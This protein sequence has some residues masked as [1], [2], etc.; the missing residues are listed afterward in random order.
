M[1]IH[2][3]PGLEDDLQERIQNLQAE[4]AQ[5]A[6]SRQKQIDRIG[7]TEGPPPG[8]QAE[9]D[10]NADLY[11]K[12]EAW[13]ALFENERRALDGIYPSPVVTETMIGDAAQ[14]I[15]P[16]DP[17]F[18]IPPVAGGMDPVYANCLKGLGGADPNHETEEK[19]IEIARITT[20]LGMPYANRAASA[21]YAQWVASLNSQTLLLGTQVTNASANE[22]YGPTHPDVV[23]AQA[24]KDAIDSLLPAPPYDDTTLNDRQAQATAR[25]SFLPTRVATLTADVTPLYDERYTILRG[26]TNVAKGTLVILEGAYKKIDLIDQFI[27]LND[28]LIA[29]YQSVLP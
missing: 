3:D 28:D 12:I 24:E 21:A 6:V 27:A 26:R 5:Y 29:F 18:P 13:I 10:I 11:P 8:L 4:N 9:E 14:G 16:I 19:V 17:I 7:G 25:Q 20:L 23:A 15:R 22:T 2:I 1:P